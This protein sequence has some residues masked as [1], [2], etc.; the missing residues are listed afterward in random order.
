MPVMATQDLIV[1]LYGEFSPLHVSNTD[2]NAENICIL[3]AKKCKI[4]PLARH[5]FGLFHPPTK[6][7]L[8]PYDLL[9]DQD[10]TDSTGYEFR[11]RFKLPNVGKLARIDIAA[12]NYYFHQVVINCVL[13]RIFRGKIHETLKVK[14]KALGLA[15]TD[16]WRVK[17]EKNLSTQAIENDYKNYLPQEV[18][19]QFKFFFLSRF[20]RKAMGDALSKLEENK[21]ELLFV[22]E[23][24]IQTILDLKPNYGCEEYCAFVD[25]EGQSIPVNLQ[26][27]PFHN[28]QPGLRR[29]MGNKKAP[30]THVCSIEELC[31]IS[32]GKDRTVEISR[33]NGVPQYFRFQKLGEMRSFVSLLDGYYRL[34]EKWTFNLC[35]ELPTPSLRHLRSIKCHGPV[36]K[37]F[38]YNKL[39]SKSQNQCGVFILRE[40]CDYSSFILDVILAGY[41][42]PTS[43]HVIK[44]NTG[45]YRLENEDAAFASIQDLLNYYI[46][47]NLLSTCIPPSEYDK[48]CL[49]LCKSEKSDYTSSSK[50]TLTIPLCINMKNLF[51]SGKDL[52][53]QGKFTSVRQSTWKKGNQNIS[54]CLKTLKSQFKH[55]HLHDFL[56]MINSCIYCHNE[57]IVSM[58]GMVINPPMIVMEYLPLGPLDSYLTSH[59]AELKEVD[60]V[61]AA[62]YLAK[63][64]WYLEEENKCHGNIRCSNVLVSAHESNSFRVKLCDFGMP[65][66]DITQIHWIPPECYETLH[67]SCHSLPADV[68]AFGTTIWE[69]FSYGLLPLPTTTPEEAKQLYLNGIRLPQPKHCDQDIYKLM[70]DC[71]VKDPDSRKKPQAIMRDINQ[72]LYEAYN[73]RRT[74]EYAIVTAPPHQ[75]ELDSISI[76][77]V[78]SNT[79][80]NETL[81][82]TPHTSQRKFQDF[83]ANFSLNRQSQIENNDS[84]KTHN[85]NGNADRRGLQQSPSDISLLM[86][87]QDQ[88]WLIEMS[89]LEKKEKLGQGFYG[90]VYKA[91]LTRWSGLGE[92]IVAIK[93]LKSGIGSGLQDLLREISIMKT[94]HHK[95]IVEIKGVVEEPEML[96]VMEFVPLSSLLVYLRTYKSHLSE[97]QL[98]KFAMDIAEGMEYLGIKRIV[99]RDLAA[100]NILV[101]TPNSVKI[102]DFGL[103]QLMGPKDYY[104]Y[105][106]ETLR[107]WKFT[108][109]SDVWS[110]GITLWEMFTFGEEPVLDGCQ[111]DKLL[112]ELESGKRLSCPPSAS[113]DIYS[114]VMKRCWDADPKL[115]PTFT[116]LVAEF[117]NMQL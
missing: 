62:T 21:Q 101:E 68:W 2:D 4:G 19:N 95:N 49:L 61:E 113:I 25:E 76:S 85:E 24:Y 82:D 97:K 67:T 73:S 47:Q 110:Y 66:C 59:C 78:S 7:W 9:K 14:E 30:W 81:P 44:L 80:D 114:Y 83:F 15:V 16:M 56:N 109:K 22:K 91:S 71:W 117:T 63:A 36:D 32:M 48:S 98:I 1:L 115:R 57:A 40:N 60:L 42:F 107:H 104:R 77:T 96:L 50:D 100:R 10:N 92:E 26:M 88:E 65:S 41:E 54:C 29:Q 34:T 45:E 99:H 8:S 103:A 72:T 79:T 6:T 108:H 55:S 13:G 102:S 105:A 111:D 64:L 51:C 116:E 27:D 75:V 93:Q 37:E 46:R 90:E 12:F 89:Q 23:Q 94:L 3:A 70:I 18:M 5:L 52:D 53:F 84:A 35:K 74:H 33:R 43:I 86:F 17:L 31:F 28:T 112:H 69:I 20:L 38:A 106:P 87:S 58:Y 39:M 11:L